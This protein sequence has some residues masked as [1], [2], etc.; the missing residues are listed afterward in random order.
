FDRAD[1]YAATIYEDMSVLN[2]FRGILHEHPSSLT[3][4]RMTAEWCANVLRMVTPH[5][6]LC[7]NLLEQVDRAALEGVATV[8]EI[9]GSY[10]IEKR[11]D[12]AMDDFELALLP[13]LPIESRRITMLPSG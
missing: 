13:I 1:G 3:D 5:M 10:K 4:R 9:G 8:T 2:F 6:W 11:H 12:C 7:G